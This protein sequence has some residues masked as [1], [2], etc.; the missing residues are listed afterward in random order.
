MKDS[1]LKKVVMVVCSSLA[2]IGI[3]LI[4]VSATNTLVIGEDFE[5]VT[6]A[7]SSGYFT[8]IKDA[9]AD[10][11]FVFA[12]IF[13]I[14]GFIIVLAC[15]LYFI[16]LLVLELMNKKEII[17][18]LDLVTKIMQG[19]LFAGVILVLCAGFDKKVLDPFEGMAVET[20]SITLFG[21]PAL[22]ALASGASTI[23]C[24]HLMKE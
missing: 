21:V 16:G 24:Q 4:K 18:K 9:A 19:V 17:T 6:N 14:V 7:G 5:R 8:F 12:R 15:V 22:I 1:F 20:L 3:L 10:K 11:S 23:A 13:M 2:L